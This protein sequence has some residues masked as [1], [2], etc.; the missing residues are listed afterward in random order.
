MRIFLT[1]KAR[2]G[3]ST[4]LAKTIEILR[5]R[6]LKIGGIVTPE[7]C[8]GRRVGFAVFD[9]ATR[10]KGILASIKLKT[11][12]RLGK[13]RIDVDGFEAIAL[14][15]LDLAIRECDIVIIDEIGKMEF[16]SE[17][18]KQKLQEVLESDKP[19]IAVVHRNFVEKFRKYGRVIEVTKE[20]REDLP[21]E[22][23][24]IMI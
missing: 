1:G 13:Y 22:I 21:K 23:V 18:F 24:K 6:R 16:F 9:V 17:K 20:N 12:P 19:L 11:G 8:E 5:K 15:A 2:V 14:P 10:K 7:I 3:K 4:V